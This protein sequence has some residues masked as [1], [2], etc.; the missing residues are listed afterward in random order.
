M[1][2]NRRRTARFRALAVAALATCL[3]VAGCSDTEAP[4]DSGATEDVGLTDSVEGPK[5]TTLVEVPCPWGQDR[6]YLP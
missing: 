4:K 6:D 2:A 1:P 3:V 5:W